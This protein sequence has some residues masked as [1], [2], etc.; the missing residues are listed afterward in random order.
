MQKD[1]HINNIYRAKISFQ[2]KIIRSS[3]SPRH[4]RRFIVD[5]ANLYETC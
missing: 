4:Y 3:L 2:R 1:L 5:E